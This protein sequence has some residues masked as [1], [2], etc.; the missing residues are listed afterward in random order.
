MRT[1]DRY[2]VLREL[3]AQV[4]KDSARQLLDA[5]HALN[6]A[7]IS[8]DAALDNPGS[9]GTVRFMVACVALVIASG[10]LA[11]QALPSHNDNL[12]MRINQAA[13][14]LLRQQHNSGATASPNTAY[15]SLPDTAFAVQLLCA[16]IEIANPPQFVTL[17]EPL[18]K[19]ETFIR[20]AVSSLMAGC[21]QLPQHRWVIASALAQAGTLLRDLDVD[22]AIRACVREG[23]DN[24]EE[25]AFL[26]NGEDAAFA[27]AKVRSLLLLA[28]HWGS[29]ADKAEIRAVVTAHLNFN[30]RLLNP[31]LTIERYF[32]RQQEYGERVI[33]ATLIAP[34]LHSSAIS[35]SPGFARAAIALW[36]K[37][38]A[39]D[40]GNL[41]WVA[42]TLQK[43]GD[44][45]IFGDNEDVRADPLTRLLPEDYAIHF[46]LNRLWRI[47]R[48]RLSATVYGGTTRLMT[49][50]FG[51]AEL[52]S[53][54]INQRASGRFMG[55][56][57]TVQGDTA[58]LR[59]EIDRP[60]HQAAPERS[61]AARQRS[62]RAAP[63]ATSELAI[64]EV[65][66]GFDLYYRLFTVSSRATIQ[67]AFDFPVGGV[68]ET[69]DAAFYPHSRQIIN[70][71]QGYG[72]MWYNEDA[73]EIRP[74]ADAPLYWTVRDSEPV[75]EGY[76]R[77]LLTLLMQ[78]DFGFSLR[79]LRGLPEVPPSV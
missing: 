20:R 73:I 77:V 36:E 34:F 58:V 2:H 48:G 32:S 67:I 79:V 46:P 14:Y 35:W 29:E 74:A 78:T 16:V 21:S 33:P 11:A 28:D 60:G 15:E 53:L 5:A 13:D 45:A 41:F 18:T 8:R 70:L 27:G 57:L 72:R 12:L 59:A 26:N 44:R 10:A 47:R 40:S 7:Y 71:R 55:S 75:N 23:Y 43:F 52:A 24:D 6:G 56:S 31:D 50:I 39:L 1:L 54:K 63:H 22:S 61:D 38:T 64:T 76:V 42:Y 25:G 66:D 51:E 62:H 65:K 19:I 68:W 17:K 30:L 3:A 49:V 9:A 37:M 4:E 69:A